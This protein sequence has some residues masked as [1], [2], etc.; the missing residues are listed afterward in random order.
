MNKGALKMNNQ[1]SAALP[2]TLGLIV[3]EYLKGLR[4]EPTQP[5]PRVP[6][7]ANPSQ[8]G[9]QPKSRFCL[10]SSATSGGT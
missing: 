5:R 6:A 10:I 2:Q 7:R 3:R 4:T 9:V 8:R 1:Q